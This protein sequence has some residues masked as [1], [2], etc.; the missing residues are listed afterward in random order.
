MK[1][2][3]H[4]AGLTIRTL[5]SSFYYYTTVSAMT[6]LFFL[7]NSKL[8]PLLQD[9]ALAELAAGQL[10][11]TLLSTGILLVFMCAQPVFIFEKREG[12]LL[13]LLYSPASAEE[14]LLGKCLGVIAMAFIGSAFSLFVPLLG[15]P[16][17]MK[18]FLS[19]QIF[20][21]LLIIFTIVFSYAAIIGMALLC[22]QNIKVLY[23]ILFFIN[24]V[25]MQLQKYSKAYMEANGLAGTNWAHILPMVFILSV[26]VCA[27]KF[28]FSRHRIIASM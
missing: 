6:V 11:Y 19:P 23:P 8:R 13:P 7:M 14:I 12:S 15:F 21:A 28:Y 26:A 20:S 2:T 16:A 27:Y 25:P 22:F 1:Y 5:F 3:L 17:I 9:K 24:Y 10:I 18:A 4:F